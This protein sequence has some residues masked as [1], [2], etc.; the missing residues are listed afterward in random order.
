MIPAAGIVITQAH[1]MFV[2]IPH[3]TAFMRWMLPTP[4]IAPAIACVV[5]TGTPSLDEMKTDT[6]A[7]VSA[8]KPLRGLSRVSLPPIV[9]TMRQPPVSVPRPIAEYEAI[10]TQYGTFSSGM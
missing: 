5:D 1:T 9:R 2:A 8:Q 7:P 10:R 4:A 6:A 3:R